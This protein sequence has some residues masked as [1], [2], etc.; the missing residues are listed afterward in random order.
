[1]QSIQGDG[2]LDQQHNSQMVQ[3]NFFVLNF[4]LLCKFGLFQ[5]F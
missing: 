4:Q 3:K 5:T 2:A 1:M